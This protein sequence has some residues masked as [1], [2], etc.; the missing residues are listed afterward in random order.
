MVRQARN[1]V[2]A[3]SMYMHHDGMAWLGIDAPVSGVM[4][5]PFA[6]DAL[7]CQTLVRDGLAWS[8]RSFI[9]DIE[10]PSTAMN[11]PAYHHDAAV[12]IYP[13]P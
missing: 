8:V 9:A 6:L 11:T 4:A 13:L 12:L 5:P 10:A 2:A 1:I 3:R 7:L